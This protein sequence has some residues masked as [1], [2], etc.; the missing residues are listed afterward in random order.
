MSG[1]PLRRLTQDR[2]TIIC[3]GPGGVGKTTCAAAIALEGARMG[4]R[5]CVV[6]IDPA[7]RLADALGLEG[8]SNEARR[9]EWVSGSGGSSECGG[10]GGEGGEGGG[11]GELWALMLDTKT[12]F[13][14]VVRRNAGN[15]EQAQA[16]LDNRLYRNISGALGGTQEYMAMEKL[17]ELHDCGNFDLIV[18]D[19][20]PT[21]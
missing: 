16:I 15:D 4:R 17:Y 8:L 18:V 14:E 9:V 11:S 20:P 21:R 12:T 13:D 6:T 19:T 1:A 7:K 2:Q 3:A 10:E 5:A